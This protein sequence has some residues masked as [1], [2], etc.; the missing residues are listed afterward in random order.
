MI[1]AHAQSAQ[2]QKVNLSIVS[3]PKA[4]AVK[5]VELLV[6]PEKTVK[7]VLPTHTVSRPIKVPL[8]KEWRLGVSSV[9]DEGNFVFKTLGKVK[10]STKKDQTLIV[11]RTG[12]KASPSFEI[13]RL[14]GDT[15][16][17]SGGS[18]FFYNATKIG[19]AGKVGDKQFALKPK[20]YKLI[21]AN[22]SFERNG[23]QYLG[24]EFFYQY[25]DIEKFDSTTWR[26]ND[27]VRYMV[28]FF[29]SEKTK[30][31][32]KHMLRIYPKKPRDLPKPK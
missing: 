3:F 30:K 18:Q 20:E 13:V 4:F 19:I 7:L 11:F 9:D 21:R 25:K 2:T 27:K 15:S 6:E 22:P 5:P 16:G 28:F 26:T 29:H 32:S 31:I 23:R 12:P 17:F 1:S 14:D 10:A 24:V 8:L